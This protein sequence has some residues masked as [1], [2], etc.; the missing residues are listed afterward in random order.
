VRPTCRSAQA[1]RSASADLAGA[2]RCCH[3]KSAPPIGMPRGEREDQHMSGLAVIILALG[4]L[5]VGSLFIHPLTRCRVCK[6]GAR[7]RGSF[8]TGSFRA[9]RKCGG[10]GRRERVG[11]GGLRAMGYDVGP[12]GRRRRK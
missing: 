6:G 11:V 9:C 10:T 5:W 4:A 1:G 2:G 7:H 3:A 12:T 8:F